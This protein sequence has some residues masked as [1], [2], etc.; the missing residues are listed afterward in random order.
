MA[1]PCLPQSAM[2]VS[3][4]SPFGAHYVAM[5]FLI[6]VAVAI[7]NSLI[8]TKI[9]KSTAPEMIMEIPSYQIPHFGTLMK[10]LFLRLK[11]FFVDA[12]PAII[13]GIFFINLFDII[14]LLAI[15]EKVSGPFVTK[16]LGLPPESVSAILFGFLRK[17]TSIA[18]LT[19]LHL[20]AKQGVIGSI[21]LVLYLPCVASFFMI[22]KETGWKYTLRLLLL[23]LSWAT[24]ICFFLNL[25]WK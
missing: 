7:F 3:L 17:D 20:T 4:L 11:M 1:A 16:I 24:A 9:L 5:V 8:L 15:I 19:P 12:V 18:T 2:I 21:F 22:L 14:G 10:K 25:F 13:V 6:L 23:T